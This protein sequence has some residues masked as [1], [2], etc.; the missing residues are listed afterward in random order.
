[1]E[2]AGLRAALPRPLR[3]GAD[4]GLIPR[5]LCSIRVAWAWL[6]CAALQGYKHTFDEVEAELDM[7]DELDSIPQN[8]IDDPAEET[9]DSLCR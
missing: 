6:I 3:L 2:G 8:V 9:A 1:M 4:P 7:L 5:S